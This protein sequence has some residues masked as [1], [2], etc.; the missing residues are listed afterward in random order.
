MHTR[1]LLLSGGVLACAAFV[2]AVGYDL[3]GDGRPD[4]ISLGSSDIHLFVTRGVQAGSLPGPF[5][6]GRLYQVPPAYVHLLVKKAFDWDSRWDVLR[7][8][9][10]SRGAEL[11]RLKDKAHVS[12]HVDEWRGWS[13][14]RVSVRN[15]GSGSRREVAGA[16]FQCLET[17]LFYGIASP[18]TVRGF[19]PR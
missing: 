19:A 5:H 9:A 6:G 4:S 17:I 14:V 16:V 12:V 11:L 2:S 7:W 10:D 13:L 15:P 1:V 3:D 18:R 8:D